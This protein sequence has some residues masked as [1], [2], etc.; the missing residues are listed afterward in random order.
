M[1][2]ALALVLALLL[3]GEIAATASGLPV[4]GAALGL[5]ALAVVFAARGGASTEM[6]RLFDAVAPNV[7]LLFVP[8]AASVIARPG[9]LMQV[10]AYLLVA[11]VPGTALALVVAGHAAQALLGGAAKRARAAG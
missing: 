9:E 6:D 3:F 2:R 8:A 7:P 1:I 10:W 5:L 4:P 11:V